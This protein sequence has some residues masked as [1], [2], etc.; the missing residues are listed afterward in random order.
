MAAAGAKLTAFVEQR[1]ID[2]GAG[3]PRIARAKTRDLRREAKK[4]R[5]KRAT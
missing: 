5:G 3:L 4:T 1:F 2:I